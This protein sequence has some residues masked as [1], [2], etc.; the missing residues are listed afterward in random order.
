MASGEDAEEEEVAGQ[1]RRKESGFRAFRFGSWEN[2]EEEI[3]GRG[4]KV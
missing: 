3:A 2:E 1:S 4:P